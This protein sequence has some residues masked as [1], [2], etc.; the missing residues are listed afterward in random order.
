MPAAGQPPLS[1]GGGRSSPT[2]SRRR[3]LL[4]VYR[5]AMIDAGT[6]LYNRRY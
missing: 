4:S 5:M 2:P 1:G 3:R 6:G